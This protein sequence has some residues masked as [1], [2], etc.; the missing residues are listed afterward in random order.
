MSLLGRVVVV[1]LAATLGA[2]AASS[3]TVAPSSAEPTVATATAGATSSHAAPTPTPAATPTPTPTPAGPFHSAIY[4]YVVRSPAWT[5]KATTT[6]WDGT[7][8]PG[9]GDG[10]VDTLIGPTPHTFAY[11]EPTTVALDTLVAT[12]RTTNS[13]AHAC[14]AK[15]DSTTKLKIGGAPALLDSLNCGVFVLTAYVVRSGRA[16]VFVMYD[17]PGTEAADRAGFEGL[18]KAVSFEP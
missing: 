11:G 15:P 2:C 6:R 4:G 18:L 1:A 17:Q 14:P 10:F 5:G 13:T 3:P 7:G 9:D 16:Y 8:A 12:S